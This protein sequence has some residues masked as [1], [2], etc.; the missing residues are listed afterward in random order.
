M[1]V[2]VDSFELFKV[3]GD[4]TRL[5][6]FALLVRTSE[7]ICV[8]E[9]VDALEVPQY[10]ISKA[11]KS[12]ASRGLLEQERD[13]RWIYYRAAPSENSVNLQNFRNIVAS[14]DDEIFYTDLKEFSKRLT[15]REDGRCRQGI[16]KT[17][18][19]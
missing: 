7:D 11:V 1:H 12:L 10:N 2:K 19:T 14:L 15:C 6:I 16:L 9:L 18:L 3:L 5:R 4:E 13:G 17:H 8:C